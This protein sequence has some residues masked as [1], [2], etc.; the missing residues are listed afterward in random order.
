MVE[1]NA[2]KQMVRHREARSTMQILI[3]RA[4]SK[5]VYVASFHLFFGF[6]HIFRWAIA[7]PSID[8]VTY[9]RPG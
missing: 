2:L 5:N 9:L 4:A 8:H 7:S 3:R 6:I 1:I